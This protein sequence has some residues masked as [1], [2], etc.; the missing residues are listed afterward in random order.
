M[1]VFTTGKDTIGYIS[2]EYG[3]PVTKIYIGVTQ[4]GALLTSTQYKLIYQKSSIPQYSGN[5]IVL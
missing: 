4:T 5:W 2:Q 3:A 1:S